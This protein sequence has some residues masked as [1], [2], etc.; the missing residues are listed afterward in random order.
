[1]RRV[2]IVT[3]VLAVLPVGL[4][5][6]QL[7]AQESEIAPTSEDSSKKEDPPAAIEEAEAALRGVMILRVSER[8]LEQVFA[9]DIDKHSQVSRVVLGT[10]ARGSAH[11]K[12]RADVDTKPDHNN[13]AFYV[14]ISGSTTA[15][16]V[17]HNGPAVIHSR[18]VT[19]WICQKTVR[20]DGEEFKA[21]PA[22][23]TSDTRITPLGAGST[24]PGLRGRIVS[25]VA[26]RRAIECNRTAERISG[27]NTE[28]QVLADVDRIVDQRIGTLNKRI[29]S[30]PI[31]AF[32][33]PK[34][35]DMGVQFSTSSNCINVSFAGGESSPQAKVCPVQG[36]K[37]SDTE[38][39][40]QTALIARPD[41]EIPEMIDNAGAWLAEML[42]D[43]EIPGVDLVGKEGVLPVDL[44]IIDDWVV[45]RSSNLD[46]NV[47]TANSREE[48][49]TN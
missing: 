9:R 40:F 1:M 5:E 35:E 4:Q 23:I 6:Y 33:L 12:G 42:P 34:L 15:R 36:L 27:R 14:R 13:A 7:L 22:T 45:L 31:M 44:E 30:R 11:T 38:L 28:K 47:T 37:P 46:A 39:W 29:E 21:G 41:G 17:G 20:F 26:T 32:L 16:T 48:S 19:N 18:S 2:G 43:V 3:L 25:N 10:R 8:Y 24:L 49:S